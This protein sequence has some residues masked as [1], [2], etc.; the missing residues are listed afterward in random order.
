[1]EWKNSYLYLNKKIK[2]KKIEYIPLLCLVY[3][4]NN[5]WYKPNNLELDQSPSIFELV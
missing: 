5:I 3:G 4:H 2:N 1:M